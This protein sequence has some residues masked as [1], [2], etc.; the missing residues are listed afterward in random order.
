MFSKMLIITKSVPVIIKA[1]ELNNNNL[2]AAI[3]LSEIK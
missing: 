1:V 2:W 3:Q